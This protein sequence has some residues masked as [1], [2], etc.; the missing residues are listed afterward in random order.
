M[1]INVFRFLGWAAK[2]GYYTA[3]AARLDTYRGANHIL[4]LALEGRICLCL[5]P[6]GYLLSKGQNHENR[7]SFDIMR[8][9]FT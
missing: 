8:E 2:R 9:L 3:K 7:T 6:P 4:R 1:K 5:Y